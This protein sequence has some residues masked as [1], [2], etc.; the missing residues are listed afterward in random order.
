MGKA[1]DE[2]KGKKKSKEAQEK[3]GLD[4]S[5]KKTKEEESKARKAAAKKEKQPEVEESQDIEDLPPDERR[6]LK[7]QDLHP[8]KA[9]RKRLRQLRLTEMSCAFFY[10]PFGKSAVPMLRSA[11]KPRRLRQ[12]K[13]TEMT[14]VHFYK[15]FGEEKKSKG[16]S[17]EKPG[18]IH[19]WN[20]SL[21]SCGNWCDVS[22]C[23]GDLSRSNTSA[24]VHAAP[25][26]RWNM[27]HGER[28]SLDQL[29]FDG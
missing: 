6:K 4:A 9:G 26:L 28:I 27:S 17:K 13:L 15:P 18:W 8:A 20:V 21:V 19:K 16:A 23:S 14:A 11:C 24:T 22:S 29:G 2:S 12:L 5:G 25:K 1:K 10:K 7:A 3:G